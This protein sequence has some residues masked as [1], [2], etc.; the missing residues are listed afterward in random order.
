MVRIVYG[1]LWFWFWHQA[2][3]CYKL[4]LYRIEFGFGL[5]DLIEPFVTI[6]LID[7][8]MASH[9]SWDSLKSIKSKSIYLILLEVSRRAWN[10][11]IIIYIYQASA[12]LSHLKTHLRDKLIG[13]QF[14]AARGQ[15]V[16]QVVPGQLPFIS[17][18][19]LN[20]NTSFTFTPTDTSFLSS[21]CYTEAAPPLAIL[22]FN[23]GRRSSFGGFGVLSPAWPLCQ[24][25]PSFSPSKSRSKVTLN[26]VPHR[27][28]YLGCRFEIPLVE[29]LL[30]H[31]WTCL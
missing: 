3:D 31:P 14:L 4:W 16:W 8:L 5:C 2:F 7:C 30:Q 10:F 13:A 25:G 9:K 15:P 27:F 19:K 6:V 12:Y 18:R 17:P 23:Q 28:T 1:T 24:A 21:Q 26:L 20:S 22:S 11:G 29:H